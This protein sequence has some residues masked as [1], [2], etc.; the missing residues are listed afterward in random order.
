M[1]CPHE[2]HDI[3][4]MTSGRCDYCGSDT[5]NRRPDSVVYSGT[6]ACGMCS[7]RHPT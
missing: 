6:K 2:D 4:V 5:L 7:E 3:D 1:F